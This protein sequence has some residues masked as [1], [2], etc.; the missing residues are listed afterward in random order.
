MDATRDF[1]QTSQ[2]GPRFPPSPELDDDEFYKVFDW[3]GYCNSTQPFDQPSPP[4]SYP[5][6]S[7]PSP[8]PPRDLSRLIKDI[9]AVIENLSLQTELFG[10]RNPYRS[11]DDTGTPS[12]YSGQTPPDLIQGGS[13]SPSDH[14]GSA[15]EH[16]EENHPSPDVTLQEV[17]AQDDEWTYPRTQPAKGAPRHYP[18]SILVPDDASRHQLPGR[19]SGLK[20]SG[21]KSIHDKRTRQ[22]VDPVKTADVRKSG[23]C[24]PCRVSK[25]RCH[26]NGVCPTCRKAFPDHSHLACNRSTPAANFPVISKTPD[27]W[28]TNG[29]EE[30]QLCASPQF[31][32]GHPRQ[33]SI[34]F[35]RNT[36]GPS[37]RATVQTYRCQDR[38]ED[39]GNPRKVSFPREHV[40]SHESLERWVEAQML[41]EEKPD[42]RYS[43]QSFLMAYSH[44]GRGLPKHKL[45]EKVHKLNCFFRIW[46]TSSFW[47]LDPSDKLVMLPLS[48]QAQLRNIARSALNL[49]EYD[50]LKELD[51]L[52]SQQGSSKAQEKLR[53]QE[54]GPVWAS[55][56]QVILIYR[57]LIVAFRAYLAHPQHGHEA[58]HQAQYR[59]LSD[60]FF[61][62]MSTL[63]HYQFRTRQS[64]ELSLEWLK[65]MPYPPTAFRRSDIHQLAQQLLD[66]RKAMY[67]DIQSSQYEIDQLLCVFVVNHELKKLNARKR[68][69]RPSAKSKGGA[70]TAEDDCEND[71]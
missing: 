9:P 5:G 25:T 42:F 40:P 41:A 32:T 12:D 13:T 18:P 34:L 22:L 43:L 65:A 3:E 19:T 44:G 11:G 67:T 48:I 56:W 71:E 38:S 26:E 53:A 23:A 39:G 31:H 70:G 6:R 47:C 45:V 49:V 46:R 33:I 27:V 36:A 68:A 61:P 1:S 17:Q 8:S 24:L 20:R 52:L 28:S 10:M 2:G 55:L 30:E 4:S 14:S 16:P 7:S 60:G 50:V 29:R 69:P 64:L 54:K 57:D 15:L 59:R 37:L 66:G 63:Y 62:L 21:S 35:S 51:E 58:S